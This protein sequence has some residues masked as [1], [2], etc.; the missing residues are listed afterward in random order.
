MY[1]AGRAVTCREGELNPWRRR[2]NNPGKTSSEKGDKLHYIRVTCLSEE[3]HNLSS[4]F[5]RRRTEAVPG[6]CLPY[7]GWAW[8]HA[9]ITCSSQQIIPS[10]PTCSCAKCLEII[11]HPE[12]E[13]FLLSCCQGAPSKAWE[14][15]GG[16]ESWVGGQQGH[17]TP[18]GHISAL[19]FIWVQLTVIPTCFHWA[20]PH[21]WFSAAHEKVRALFMSWTASTERDGAASAP[22]LIISL[23]RLGWIYCS[24]QSAPSTYSIFSPSL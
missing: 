9:V 19:L 3:L 11:H 8:G 22:P 24:C 21:V 20:E 2:E 16:T 4:W 13:H 5:L 23:Q 14:K 7:K 17:S 1:W 12:Q 10:I 15:E 18:V 6:L